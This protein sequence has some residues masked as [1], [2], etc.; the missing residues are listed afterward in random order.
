MAVDNMTTRLVFI[1]PLVCLQDPHLQNCIH[2]MKL[3]TPAMATR[4]LSTLSNRTSTGFVSDAARMQATVTWADLST[5]ANVSYLAITAK[6]LSSSFPL[7]YRLVLQYI[8]TL[9]LLHLIPSLSFCHLIL[10]TFFCINNCNGWLLVHIRFCAFC[11]KRVHVTRL[12]FRSTGPE[13][14]FP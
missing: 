11:S 3:A 10:N 2:R 1:L 6:S 8:C 14:S 7:I 13:Q 12:R 5:D 4:T 9:P